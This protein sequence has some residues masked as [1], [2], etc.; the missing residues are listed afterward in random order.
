[1]GHPTEAKLKDKLSGARNKET[2]LPRNSSEDNLHQ[3]KW[4]TTRF[5]LSAFHILFL[6]ET[7]YFEICFFFFFIKILK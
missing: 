2:N 7:I 1:M 6:I 5:P 4:V 3:K